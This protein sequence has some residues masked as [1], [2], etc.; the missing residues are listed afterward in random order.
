MENFTV[1]CTETGKLPYHSPALVEY[2]SVRDVTQD[3]ALMF[4]VVTILSGSVAVAAL[5]G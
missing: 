3:A 2:G 1:V 5:K 4:G